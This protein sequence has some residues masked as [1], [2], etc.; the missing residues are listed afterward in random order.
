MINDVPLRL[1]CW[2]VWRLWD[3]LNEFCVWWRAFFPIVVGAYT[4]PSDWSNW[5]HS[6]VIFA[7]SEVDKRFGTTPNKIYTRSKYSLTITYNQAPMSGF[8]RAF[9]FLVAAG[10]GM[11]S[12]LICRCGKCSWRNTNLCLGVISGM[13]IFKPLVAREAKEL[14]VEL[15]VTC[16]WYWRATMRQK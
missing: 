14:F 8:R 16:S 2:S 5:R 1:G 3:P 11:T 7:D 9:P 6:H 10:T 15:Q 13:Y 4:A 12:D